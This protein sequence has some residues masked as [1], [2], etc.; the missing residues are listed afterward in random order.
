VAVR[1]VKI[2]L[3]YD[4]RDFVGWQRQARGASVQGLVEEAL[5]A[6]DGRAVAVVGAGRTDAG[7]HAMG[8]VASA[9]LISD[10]GASAVR[11]ALNAR[12]PASVR[13]LAVEDAPPGF[14]ARFDATSKTYRYLIVNAETCSPFDAGLAWHVRQPLD[15]EAVGAAAK[16]VEGRH[17][18]AAF[19]GRRTTLK[20][21]V[22][23]VVRSGVQ[24]GRNDRDGSYR[25]EPSARTVVYEIAGNGFLRHMVRSIVGTLVEIGHGRRPPEAMAAI[26][27]SRDRRQA[28]PTAPAGGLYL[29]QVDFGG[30]DEREAGDVG[31]GDEEA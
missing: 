22:R 15:V 14:N 6:I 9:R 29:M 10:I 23:R 7:V 31:E 1:T 19:Q 3:A 12:L 18:F 5:A 20:S 25:P 28:G 4:G 24:A 2:V 8:Q 17:D 30:S 27:A 26:L 11:R 21:T 16:L 13:A